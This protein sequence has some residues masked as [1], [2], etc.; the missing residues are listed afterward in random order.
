MVNETKA[1]GTREE[2]PTLPITPEQPGNKSWENETHA[3][4]EP[5]IP[6]V[7]PA[8]NRVLAQVTNVGNTGLVAR[9]EQHPTDMREPE[10]LVSVIRVEVG[11]RITVVGT[12]TTA[13][14]LNGALDRTSSCYSQEVLKRLRRVVRPMRPQP[15]IASSDAYGRVLMA[16]LR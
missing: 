14:P 5:D 11:I 7:L 4:N 8:D 2:E 6:A 9:L 1:S 13:P 15:V 3:D 16:R 12:V 10:A